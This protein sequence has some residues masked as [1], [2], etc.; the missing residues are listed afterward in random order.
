MKI[1][2]K[3]TIRSLLVAGMLFS[4]AAMADV[5]LKGA[6]IAKLIVGNTIEGKYEACSSGGKDF[7]EHYT[8]DGKIRGQE[9]PC[10]Q[11]GQWQHYQGF[12]KVK[13]DKFCVNLGSGRIGGCFD[14]VANPDGTV[15][16][17]MEGGKSSIV[18]QIIDGNPDHL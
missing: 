7:Q 10:A 13:D 4:T 9:R 6:E 14:Y 15:T 18:F 5:Y 16:R 8:S 2:G 11:E 12:W 3:L 1:S 17:L